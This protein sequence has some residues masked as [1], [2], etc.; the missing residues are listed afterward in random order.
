MDNLETGSVWRNKKNQHVYTVIS[1]PTHSETLEP[2][3]NYVAN[4]TPSRLGIIRI[5]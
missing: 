2:M 5:R 1:L 4:G 3:V